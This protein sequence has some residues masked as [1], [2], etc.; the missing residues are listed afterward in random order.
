MDIVRSNSRIASRCLRTITRS[1]MTDSTRKSKC[2]FAAFAARA[3]GESGVLATRQIGAHRFRATVARRVLANP[4]ENARATRSPRGTS[5]SMRSSSRRRNPRTAREVRIVPR[6][7]RRFGGAEPLERVGHE[8][9]GADCHRLLRVR[10]GLVSFQ[11]VV[12]PIMDAADFLESPE[13]FLAHLNVEVDLVVEGTFLLVQFGQP[14][15]V[16]RNTE[17]VEV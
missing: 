13:A 4:P 7:E 3:S 9:R 16:P 17:G 8:H 1:R 6:G 15:R 14:E 5:S 10:S 11:V 12:R 2:C